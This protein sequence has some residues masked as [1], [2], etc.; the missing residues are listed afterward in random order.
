MLE[1]TSQKKMSM[2]N[3]P[4]MT[5]GIS[6]S[7]VLRRQEE[8]GF[9]ELPISKPRRT[10]SIL[11]GVLSEPMVYIL[12]GCGVIYFLIG[13]HQEAAM[14]IGFLFLIVFIE[15][16][17]E[18]KAERALDA[19][20]NLSSP[21]ALVFR[22]GKKQRIPGR[23]L[24]KDD[25]IFLSE[26]DKVPADAT[27]SSASHLAVDESMLTGESVS[28]EK[29]QHEAVFAGT[30]VVRGQATAIITSIG[31][32]TKIGEIGKSLA[33][34]IREKTKLERETATLVKKVAW[35]AAAICIFV[36]L[37]YAVTR[38][39]WLEGFLV[40]LTL[41]MAIL[42]NEPPAVL[43]IFLALGAWRLSQRRVLTRKLA[44]VENL[45]SATV[46]CV[47][48][49]GTL[50][51][52][53]MRIQS[54]FSKQKYIDLTEIVDG[55]LPEEFHEALEFGI[56]ASRTDPFDPME[57]AF[58]SAGA[59]FLSGTEHL[60]KDWSL[61]K[62]YPISPKLLAITHA[63]RKN[64]GG[65]FVIGAKGAP[66]AI[67]DLCHLNADETQSALGHAEK[68]ASEGLRVLGVAKAK[69][70]DTTLPE[71]QHDFDFEFLGYIG[72]ADPIRPEVPR[73]V[74]ECHAAGV[75][76]VM[77]TGDHPL[78]ALSIA[79]KIGLNNSERV[80]TGSEIEKLSDKQ[81]STAL[82]QINV[83]SRVS[84]VQKLKLVETFKTNGEIVAMTG[85]G[86]NDAPALKSAHIGIAMGGRGTDV[87]R[88]SAA[89]VLLDDDFGSIV[90]AI[91]MGRRIYINLKSAMVYLFS[92]HVPIAGM[93]I[94]P[95]LFKLPLVL[96]PAHIAL[97][98]LI[99]EPAS[100]I[101]FEV[102]PADVNIMSVPP[103]K[104]KV[105]L[106]SRDLWLPSLIRGFSI[107]IA[108]ISVFLIAIWRGQNETEA[109][110][111][112]FTTLM[113]ANLVLI[114]ISRSSQKTILAKFT[115]T[116]NH[117]IEW[118]AVGTLIL[119]VLILY[120]PS[121][122]EVLRFSFLHPN[123]LAICAVVGIIS[124]IWS[125]FLPKKWLETNHNLTQ[126]KIHV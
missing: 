72:I 66:E 84:A 83:F 27:L 35:I 59:K 70:S 12:L 88:E 116:K 32:N 126:R 9:N 13:D 28:V 11:F 108:L 33:S 110:A 46:L 24:V 57:L 34:G 118:I 5:D 125:Q 79:K 25:F 74:S 20:R 29:S 42:P 19:L 96:L 86:V 62:E 73:A 109:R 44:A 23:E 2:N 63:W 71:G 124:V 92:V 81:L 121:F 113:I 1:V 8:D 45:G 7:M 50:T 117:V 114:F 41:A 82:G 64:Q 16:F 100:S 47:D 103:R 107:L 48:K 30:T 91:R 90:E 87:A 52:N 56:L 93:A 58:V 40:G 85:D 22:D 95:A 51:L 111:L 97:L 78:T 99:I 17:Q 105:P 94:I 18:Q 43:T 75:R 89:L 38:D 61:E 101:A 120:I 106:F 122:R 37:V 49:T 104:S 76:V 119:L 10:L 60:H 112:V 31:R 98:H 67:V 68:L 6:L 3:R 55:I 53:Q 26:G 102:E 80:M 14:L 77:I 54:I 4:E 36:F 39:N 65:G 123:D 69:T 15:I 115:S 21:R